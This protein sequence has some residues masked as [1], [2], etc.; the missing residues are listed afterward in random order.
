MGVSS[1]RINESK[2]EAFMSKHGFTEADIRNLIKYEEVRRGGQYNMQ[3]WLIF[4][5]QMNINGGSKLAGW[6]R[7]NYKEFLAILD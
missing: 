3:E 4:M 5:A 1:I 7:Y 2:K 6:I